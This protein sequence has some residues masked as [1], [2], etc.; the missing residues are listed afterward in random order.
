MGIITAESILNRVDTSLF[1]E[2]RARWTE[3]ELL[4]YLSDAQR[5]TVQ[6]V[7]EA[8]PKN[9][10]VPLV[11]GSKQGIPGDG[12][13]LLDVIRN[14]PGQAIRRVGRSVLDRTDP[15]WHA[16]LPG[17]VGVRN[18]TYDTADRY[19]FYVYPQ[20]TSGSIEIIYSAAPGEISSVGDTI[21]VD[22]I[23]EPNL[24]HFMMYRALIKDAPAEDFKPELAE[25]HYRLFATPLL[26]KVQVEALLHPLQQME[27][28]GR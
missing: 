2:T 20:Q 10:T 16:A 13:Q 14:I 7:P 11:S 21:D 28:E 5:M 8:F 23:Y 15:E 24:Y 6:L 4:E 22:D 9:M 25:A 27:R 17:S 12:F 3:T 26:G 18:W 19:H 1:D